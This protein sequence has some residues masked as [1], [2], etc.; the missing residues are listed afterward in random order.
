MVHEGIPGWKEACAVIA[1]RLLAD[2][3]GLAFVEIPVLLRWLCSKGQ[4]S[5]VHVV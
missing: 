5:Q 3:Q 1:Q 2:A 4:H